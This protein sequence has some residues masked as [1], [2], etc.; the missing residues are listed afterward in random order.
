MINKLLLPH[1]YKFIGWCMLIPITLLGI[2]LLTTGFDQIYFDAKVLALFYKNFLGSEHSSGIIETNIIPT[3]IGTLFLIGA[4]LVGF[5]REKQEDEYIADLRQS[6]LL[7]AVLVNYLLLLIAFLFIYGVAFM[8]IM[9]YNMF[10]ILIIF[11][12]RFNFLLYRTAKAM[13]NEEYN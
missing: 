4:L 2:F 1:K 13:P 6:S 12:T 7:W 8:D 3:A 10:T 5:S 11:I 9:I